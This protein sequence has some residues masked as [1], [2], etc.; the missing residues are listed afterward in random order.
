MFARFWQHYPQGSLTSTLVTVD[1]GMYIVRA[2]IQVNNQPIASGLGAAATVE[3]AEDQARERA[4]A[5]LEF[6]KVVP[7]SPPTPE[8]VVVPEPKT[9]P[10]PPTVEPSEPSTP[11]AENGATPQAVISLEETSP[12]TSPPPP[13]PPTPVVQPEIPPEPE[14]TATLP[15]DT[16][17]EETVP[18]PVPEPMLEPEPEPESEPVPEPEAESEPASTPRVTP[19]GAP[20][21]FSDVIARTN[22]ELKRLNWTTEQGKDYLL[23]TYGKRSRQLLT[24][25]ELLEFLQYLESL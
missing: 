24:D 6:G 2:L 5:V 16:S 8:P 20:I 12:V 25:D 11:V 7:P 17:G 14:P 9:T 23:E 4:L 18:Q 10:S 13:E 22:V 19:S 3:V 1:R 21:D 15:L